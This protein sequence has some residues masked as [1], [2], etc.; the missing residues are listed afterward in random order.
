MS[1]SRDNGKQ[2]REACTGEALETVKGHNSP[3]DITFFAACFCPFVQRVWVAF[4]YL[5]IPYF[6]RLDEVDPYKKPAELLQVSPKG[7]VPGLRL[8]NY[9]PARSLNESTIILEF[10]EDSA[11]IGNGKS[12]FPPKSDPYARALVRLQCDHVNRSL[13]PAFYRYLQAQDEDSVVAGAKEFV[14]SLQDLASL[15]QRAEREVGSIACGLWTEDGDLSLTDVMAGPWLFR[16][17]NVLKYYRGFVLPPN[18]RYERW[19]ERLFSHPAFRATCSTE[20]LYMD[21]YERYA[22]NRP[23]TSQ[24]ANAINAG[25]GLP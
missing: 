16:A 15:L 2:Y 23:N 6:S 8:D 19:I 1:K 4:E 11:G 7:L 18:D 9:Q 25:R 21:S 22:F 20:D 12:L 13:V 24:V 14:A 3:Q 10:L 17:T 5:Q